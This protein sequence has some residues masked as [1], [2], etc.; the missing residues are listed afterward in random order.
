MYRKELEVELLKHQEAMANLERDHMQQ[1]QSLHSQQERDRST[2]TAQL[3]DK[4]SQE[5]LAVQ[6]V[7]E[8]ISSKYTWSRIETAEL[9]DQLA[10]NF[11]G[12][13]YTCT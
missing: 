11:N 13:V 2:L 12:A 7:R 10:S 1:I 8:Y 9:H 4:H 5:L 6:Q 3:R